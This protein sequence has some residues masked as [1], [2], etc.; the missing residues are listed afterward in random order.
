MRQIDHVH[1]VLLDGRWRTGM[2]LQRDILD[3]FGALYSDSAITAR[4]RDLRAEGLPI[5]VRT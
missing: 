5:M 1:L 3:R 4:V 2:E